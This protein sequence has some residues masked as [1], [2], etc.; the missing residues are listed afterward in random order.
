MSNNSF[1][2]SLEVGNVVFIKVNSACFKDVY[3]RQG[4]IPFD[5]TNYTLGVFKG[6]VTMVPSMFKGKKNAQT[7]DVQN[8]CTGT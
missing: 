4:G 6:E 3:D 5:L 7:L 1:F 2:D 8:Q